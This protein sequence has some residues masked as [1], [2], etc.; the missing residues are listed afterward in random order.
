MQNVWSVCVSLCVI[1][2]W[3]DCF[4]YVY[5]VRMHLCS[6]GQHCFVFCSLISQLL[7]Y[8]HT[9]QLFWREP[10]KDFRHPV[11]LGI[12]IKGNVSR[13]LFGCI[14]LLRFVCI[15]VG[16]S[17]LCVDWVRVRVCVHICQCVCVNWPFKKISMGWGG[18]LDREIEICRGLLCSLSPYE[19]YKLKCLPTGILV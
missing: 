6:G 7:N 18:G 5:R 17:L 15:Y 12:N 16:L 11:M 3:A 8:K 4:E 13:V 9:G 2:G 14:Y 10:V 19:I 1:T